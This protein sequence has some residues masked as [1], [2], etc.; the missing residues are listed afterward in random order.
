MAFVL[1]SELNQLRVD[2]KRF[3]ALLRLWT[4]V[5]RE[6]QANTIAQLDRL[7]KYN[8]GQLEYAN[9]VVRRYEENRAGRRL[10]GFPRSRKH[11]RPGN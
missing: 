8:D 1:D 5:T 11:L 4:I 3:H 2:Q 9:E 6:H 10:G 7:A